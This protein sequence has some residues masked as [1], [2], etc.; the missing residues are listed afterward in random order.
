FPQYKQKSWND[1]EGYLLTDQRHRLR[2]WAIYD[3][4]KSEHNQLNVW[5]LQNYYSGTPFG[6]VGLLDDRTFVTNP[7]YVTPPARVTYY[8][9]AR[10]AFR[11]PAISSTDISVNYSFLWNAFDQSIEL[12][13]QPEVLNVFNRDGVIIPNVS[14]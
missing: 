3:I 11:T 4:F 7:G 5:L 13:L 9:T 12:F 10:D 14:I 2:A 8:C 1:P 6:A